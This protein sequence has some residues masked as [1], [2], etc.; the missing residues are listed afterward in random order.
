MNGKELDELLTKMEENMKIQHTYLAEQSKLINALPDFNGTKQ[1]EYSS[2][3]LH[4]VR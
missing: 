2:K 4:I 1:P 3:C